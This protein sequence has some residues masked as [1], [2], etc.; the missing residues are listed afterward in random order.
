M[1]KAPVDAPKDC[2]YPKNCGWK[3]GTDGCANLL[4][5]HLSQDAAREAAFFLRPH[6]RTTKGTK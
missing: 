6:P 5:K 4:C 1:R 3:R 2:A